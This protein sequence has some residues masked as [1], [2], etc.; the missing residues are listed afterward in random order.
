M[1]A[2]DLPQGEPDPYAAARELFESWQ[3][4]GAVV[5]D[6]EPALSG[7]T[8]RTTRV[9]T[10]PRARAAASSAACASRST[11]P[12]ACARTSAPTPG[13]KEDR[14]RLTRATRANISPIFSL[15]SDPEQAAW[16]ALAP[17][18]EAPPWGEVTDGDGTVHRIWRVTDP[19]A[20]AAVQAAARARSC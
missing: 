19:A 1:V 8:P 15:Y 14:L 6:R 17:A 12:D 18:T 3:L 20:I 4:H 9:P 2:V 16:G 5:R 7:R 13:P 11:A 10:A